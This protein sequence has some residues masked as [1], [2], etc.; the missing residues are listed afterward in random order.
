[1]LI[2]QA[3]PN[4]HITYRYGALYWLNPSFFS[5]LILTSGH[6][7]AHYPAPQHPVQFKNH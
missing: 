2:N 1:V 6:S 5:F 7:G 4:G 3:L